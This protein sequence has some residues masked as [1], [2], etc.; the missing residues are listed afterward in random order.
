MA[1]VKMSKTI[2]CRFKNA[3]VGQCKKPTD[4]GLC[5][6]HEVMRCCVCGKQA[7]QTCEYTGSSPFVCGQPLCSSCQHE[8]YHPTKTPYPAKHLNAIDFKKASKDSLE[9][10]TRSAAN[11]GNA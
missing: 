1:D 5:G 6:E 3:W 9:A 8:P 10:D 4:N 2:P 7:T 11:G